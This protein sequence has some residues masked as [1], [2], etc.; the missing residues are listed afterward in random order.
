MW[1]GMS[2]S[3][4]K[5]LTTSSGI[6]YLMPSSVSN[7]ADEEKMLESILKDKIAAVRKN[8][9]GMTTVWDS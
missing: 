6:G 9:H 1:K 5:S 7:V 4:I 8:E 2:P 3:H